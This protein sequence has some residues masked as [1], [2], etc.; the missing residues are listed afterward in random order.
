L[1]EEIK[2]LR[3]KSKE[4]EKENARINKINAFLEEATRFFVEIR[5]K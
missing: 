5:Q 3:E 4:Y 2:M 1:T